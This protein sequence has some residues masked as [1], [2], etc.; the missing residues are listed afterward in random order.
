M[1]NKHIQGEL[2]SE[3]D[4]KFQ[5][6]GPQQRILNFLILHVVPLK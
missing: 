3:I 2:I 6:L 5:I 4:N 1:K